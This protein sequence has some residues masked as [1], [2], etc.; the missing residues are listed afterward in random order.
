MF[1]SADGAFR[2]IFVKAR[3]ELNGYRECTEWFEA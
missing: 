2:I 1:A 3:P